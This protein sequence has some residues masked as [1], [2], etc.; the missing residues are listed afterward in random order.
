MIANGLNASTPAALIQQG[1]T[2]NQKV[3][4]GDLRTLPDIVFSQN[5]TAPTLLIVG[6]V[7]S[8]HKSLAWF[9]PDED[10]EHITMLNEPIKTFE[11]GL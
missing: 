4:V 7:V 9:C 3:I 1:T 10:Q 8:L 11:D 2:L 5:I 6:S